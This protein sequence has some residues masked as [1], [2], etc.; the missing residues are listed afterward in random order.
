[1][2]FKI[3]LFSFIEGLTEFIPISST[4]HLIILDHFVSLSKNTQ[5]THAFSVIIQLGAILAVLVYFKD[6][7]FSLKKEDILKI[8]VAVIPA[9]IL[10]LLF[11][12]IIDHYLFNI[13]VVSSFLIIYGIILLYIEKIKFNKS[14][15]EFKNI[16]YKVAF[17]IGAFQTLALIPGTSR[18]A[19]TIIGAMILGLDKILAI[20]FSFFLA[21]PT[22]L[23]ASGLKI[24]KLPILSL[25]EYMY[26]LLGFVFSYIFAYIFIKFFMKYI[27]GHDFKLFAYYR[28]ILGLV[29]LIIL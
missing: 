3:I 24:L 18:S 10:G 11:D 1:M 8:L 28:I 23:G 6:K 9:A 5:F 13:Y 17:F 25:S 12:D 14:I 2:F 21:I 27:K 20:E 26:I 19:A 15:L 29:I 16:T 22:M 7:I 4:G